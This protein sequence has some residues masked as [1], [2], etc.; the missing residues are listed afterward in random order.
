MSNKGIYSPKDTKF[1]MDMQ[2]FPRLGQLK[3]IETQSYSSA[4][5]AIDFLTSSST[6]D[7]EGS[8]CNCFS[9]IFA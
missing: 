1:L 2:Q 3:L 5:S 9:L 6:L 7:T 4:V 8:R